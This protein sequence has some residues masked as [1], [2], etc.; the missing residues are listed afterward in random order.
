MSGVHGAVPFQ[1][2][3]EDNAEPGEVMECLI[4]NKNNEHMN[5]KC[6]AGIHHHQ[7]VSNFLNLT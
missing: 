6:A 7:L 4:E 2:K 3:I 5:D 1:D